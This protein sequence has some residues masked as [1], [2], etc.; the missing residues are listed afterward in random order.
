VYGVELAV[1]K[2]DF[3][4]NGL[5][6]LLSYTYTY[7]RVHFDTLANGSTVVTGI[8]TAISQYNAYTSKC[9]PFQ[10]TPTVTTG[11]PA[12]CLTP[13]V[14]GVPQTVALPTNGAPASPCYNADGSPNP[15]CAVDPGTGLT[16]LAN[17]YWNAPSQ[18]LF[19]ANDSFVPYNQLPGTGVS[20]VASSYIIP[21]VATLVLNFRHNRWAVTP[22]FQI[23]AGGKY[24]SPVQGQ[25]ID[26]A[27]GCGELTSS[28]TGD[29]RYP[30]GAAGGAPYDAQFCGSANGAG[31]IVTPDL[32]TNHFDNFGEFTEP[33]QINASMQISYDV[34]PK[35]TLRLIGTN[36]WNTCFGG[37]NVPWVQSHT[38]G[39]WYTSG[40]YAGNFYNPGNVVQQAF[41]FP[42]VPTFSTVFQQA[43]GGQ[44]NPFNLF[45]NAEIKL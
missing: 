19:S 5:A 15:A 45:I 22:A 11:V 44:A 39:C 18:G 35:I 17:P 9:A 14:P 7:G 2:G 37:S 38:V 25:G 10:A 21:H 36:I 6:A 28:I 42:Y 30:Y 12:E 4:R 41:R 8:N 20:S 31:S 33:T 16:S 27:S 1:Q 32:Y 26:P 34:S 13:P 23:T 40:T 24:G 3:N 43:Y 29:P